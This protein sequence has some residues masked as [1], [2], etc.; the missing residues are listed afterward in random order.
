[1]R[2]TV[3]LHGAEN[4]KDAFQTAVRMA[5]RSGCAVHVVLS[6]GCSPEQFEKHLHFVLWDVTER[7]GLTSPAIT[8]ERRVLDS[9]LELVEAQAGVAALA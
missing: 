9:T 3:V 7:L 8:C 4:D 6:G 2:I 1:M 5:A